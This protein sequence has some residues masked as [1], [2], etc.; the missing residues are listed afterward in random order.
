[1][2]P[3]TLT[4]I[5]VWEGPCGISSSVVVPREPGIDTTEWRPNP[6]MTG[7]ERYESYDSYC[8]VSWD[9]V[10]SAGL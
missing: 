2:G 7:A 6:A 10:S 4:F 3:S 9:N 1:M 5:L 8:Y